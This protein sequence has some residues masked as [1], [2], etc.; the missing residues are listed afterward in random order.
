MA[1][2]SMVIDDLNVLGSTARP[3]KADSPLVVD[4]NAVLTL[5]VTL[6]RFEAISGWNTQVVELACDFQ[7]TQLAAGHL[8]NGLKPPN[9]ISA[10]EGSRIGAPEQPNHGK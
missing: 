7:L 1:D 6:E 8:C 5:A 9:T 4:P 3:A 10:G 2:L